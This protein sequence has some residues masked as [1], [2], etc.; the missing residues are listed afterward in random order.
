[1]NL[2]DRID[3]ILKNP[4]SLSVKRKHL[5]QFYKQLEKYSNDTCE[6]AEAQKTIREVIAHIDALVG[7]L[8][9]TSWN[10]TERIEIT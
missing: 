9:P 6:I 2:Q 3:F 8:N 5:V 7:Y 1:M 4:V 10:T